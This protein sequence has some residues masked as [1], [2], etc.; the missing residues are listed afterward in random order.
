[1]RREEII[2]ERLESIEAEI[3]EIDE[4]ESGSG[5]DNTV[6]SSMQ[7]YAKALRYCLRERDEDDEI[8]LGSRWR[9]QQTRTGQVVAETQIKLA[10]PFDS[11]KLACESEELGQS[12]KVGST[13]KRGHYVL[14]REEIDRPQEQADEYEPPVEL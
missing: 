13:D 8:P 9:Q 3:D 6:L 7:A 5:E 14:L 1:M 10:N 11:V 4:D 2:K 12:V